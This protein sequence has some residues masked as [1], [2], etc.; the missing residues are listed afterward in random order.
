MPH[1][2]TGKDLHLKDLGAITQLD[3]PLPPYKGSGEFYYEVQ[4]SGLTVDDPKGYTPATGGLP[5]IIKWSADM[6]ESE[7]WDW[8]KEFTNPQGIGSVVASIVGRGGAGRGVEK[9]GAMSGAF[10]AEI[11]KK[12]AGS[13]LWERGGLFGASRI[14]SW[15]PKNDKAWDFIPVYD[16][17]TGQ[18]STIED[19]GNPQIY[20]G[21]DMKPDIQSIGGAMGAVN[22]IHGTDFAEVA[23][24]GNKPNLKFSKEAYVPKYGDFEIPKGMPQDPTS[25]TRYEDPWVQGV[26]DLIKTD[27]AAGP[28]IPDYDIGRGRDIRGVGWDF[29]SGQLGSPLEAGSGKLYIA[30]QEKRVIA[31]KPAPLT[32]Q[33]TDKKKS[34]LL[35]VWLK[36]NKVSEE[37]MENWSVSDLRINPETMEIDLIKFYHTRGDFSEIHNRNTDTGKAYLN[38]LANLDTTYRRN[39]AMGRDIYATTATTPFTT[40]S[41]LPAISSMGASSTQLDPLAAGQAGVTT[42]QAG[43]SSLGTVP[44]LDPRSAFAQL[45]RQDFERALPYALPGSRLPLVQKS[46]E[47][48][49]PMFGEAYTMAQ[50]LGMVAPD[51]D[52]QAGETDT[53]GFQRFLM[54]NPD[55]RGI[56]QQGI[57]LIDQTKAK[58]G[59]GVTNLTAIEE[60]IYANYIKGYGDNPLAGRQNEL[61]LRKDLVSFLPKATRYGAATGLERQYQTAMATNPLATYGNIYGGFNPF[62]TSPMTAMP[63]RPPTGPVSSAIPQ[64]GQQFANTLPAGSPAN[65]ATAN[66]DNIDTSSGKAILDIKANQPAATTYGGSSPMTSA[67]EFWSETEIPTGEIT[68]KGILPTKEQYLANRASYPGVIINNVGEV[69]WG[70]SKDFEPLA[71]GELRMGMRNPD[72]ISKAFPAG[73]FY[74]QTEVNLSKNLQPRGPAGTLKQVLNPVTGNFT[75]IDA[76]GKSILDKATA[77]DAPYGGGTVA[78]PYD[79]S[80]DTDTGQTRRINTRF[81]SSILSDPTIPNA[82][83]DPD[84]TYNPWEEGKTYTTPKAVTEGPAVGMNLPWEELQAMY[85][86]AG[87]GTLQGSP[88]LSSFFDKRYD[89]TD[90]DSQGTFQKNIEGDLY[91]QWLDWQNYVNNKGR[92]MTDPNLIEGWG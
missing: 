38:A 69:R 60:Q 92:M 80:T 72:T 31:G 88:P 44:S 87:V 48:S 53:L 73:K 5:I 58:V 17:T 85:K 61:S 24:K 56:L 55:I 28:A 13:Q 54:G 10:Q 52:A 35:E 59:S 46:Y 29:G 74:T 8:L 42:G 2:P 79:I 34:E 12:Y 67:S 66:L 84:F 39:L 64:G 86:R 32:A 11:D 9:A 82:G 89:P 16:A 41:S 30:G 40:P 65:I 49:V 70:E 62:A 81:P 71:K 23:G 68:P 76:E 63:Q 26:I 19:E 90:V 3:K 1:D 22:Y 77:W 57:S 15:K 18:W 91:K 75:W 36:E 50:F 14:L 47:E 83:Y 78:Y 37:E 33:V 27:T 6:T 7:R 51:P 21:K 4:D 20:L 25:P 43:L 45:P